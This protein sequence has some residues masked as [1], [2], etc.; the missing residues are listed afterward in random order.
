MS[1]KSTIW[2]YLEKV[3]GTEKGEVS[4]KCNICKNIYTAPGGTTSG[5]RKHLKLHPKQAKQ[6]KEADDEKKKEQVEKERKAVDD[7]IIDV[8]MFS[9]GPSKK[10]PSLPGFL[11]SRMKF[12]TQSE[13]QKASDDK[14]VDYI[15]KDLT[16]LNYLNGEGFV[17]LLAF[18]APKYT[19]KERKTYARKI[20]KKYNNLLQ[21]YNDIIEQCKP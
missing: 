4:G 15:I 18:A 19:V 16:T 17:D 8:E 12:D 1:S 11:E 14:D 2:E 7:D 20:E 6:L 9:Q 13:A 10:Q 5:L 21:Q 3:I